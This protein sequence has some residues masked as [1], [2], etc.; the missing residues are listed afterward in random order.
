MTTEEFSQSVKA[1]TWH[2]AAPANETARHG[3]YYQ[4][5]LELPTYLRFK[6]LVPCTVAVL[7]IVT[8]VR[9]QQ[10]AQPAAPAVDATALAKQSQNPVG[11]LVSVPF[12]FNFNTGGDL[13]ERTL[14]NVNF[15]PVIPFR[16]TDRWN[17]IARTIV[18]LESVPGDAGTRFSGVGDIQLQLFVTPAAPRAIIW[19]LGGAFSFPTATIDPVESGTWAAGPSLVLVKMTGSFVLGGLVSQIWPLADAGDAR[20]TNLLTIQ[21]AV[22]FNF[23]HGWAMAFSPV[24]T[25]NWDAPVGD[26][27]TV[28][29]GLGLTRTVVFNRR[30]MNL[31]ISYNYN[32]EHPA[33]TAG[34][35]LRFT[36]TL[37]YPR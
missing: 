7:L 18:P 15:Q 20:E 10:V 22:N 11:S 13:G 24:I 23:G 1:C 17:V 33:G 31:G 26:R 37:L 9:A 5:M 14:L 27:W 4:P 2:G 12:Q 3:E 29:V 21:P 30:P 36:V 19:G 35:Q 25:A 34:E 16:L 6:S 32:I 8:P 28:P